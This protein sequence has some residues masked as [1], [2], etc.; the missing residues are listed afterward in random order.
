MTAKDD[1]IF[2]NDYGFFIIFHIVK[3]HFSTIRQ[4]LP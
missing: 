4:V 3:M 1:I 2:M